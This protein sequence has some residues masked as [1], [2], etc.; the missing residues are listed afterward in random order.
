MR[1]HPAAF[2]LLS[3]FGLAGLLRLARGAARWDEVALAY[4]AYTEPAAQ[5]LA[6][7]EP[8]GALSSWVGLHPPLHAVIM[9]LLE[10]LWP[11]PLAWIG[12]SLLASWLAVVLIGRRA[13]WIAAAA[14]A[15]G[16]LQLA[17]CAE[18]NNYPL[19]VL[20][21]AALLVAPRRPGLGL[22]A[23][24]ALACWAHV[25]TALAA[26]AFV[27]HLAW[28]G[29]LSRS[30]QARLLGGSAL[31]AAPVVV[32]ALRRVGGEGT[33][34]QAR[35]ELS[36]W[37]E[38]AS[39]HL[40]PETVLLVALGG[41][42]LWLGG[43]R[44][45]VLGVALTLGYGAA[46]FAGAAATHQR[47]YLAL[48]GPVL[49]LGLAELPERVGPWRRAARVVLGVLLAVQ[50]GRS[51][52]SALAGAWELQ[53]AGDLERGLDRV[54]VEAA[55][56]DTVWLVAPALQPDDDKEARSPLLWRLNPAEAMPMARPVAFEYLDYRYG[57]PRTW[58]GLTVHTSVELEEQVFDHVARA[59]LAEGHQVWVV[60]YEHAPATGLEA[61]VERTLRPYALLRWSQAY[62]GVPGRLGGDGLG[63]S[64]SLGED[65][66]FQIRGLQ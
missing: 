47:P 33:F 44:P 23:A 36:T 45:R 60:L 49:A 2:G 6:E 30:N 28:T 17:Y 18:V 20:A 25:L 9:G 37:W 3:L 46:L 41:L 52:A 51:G 10:L 65:L 19:A 15:G 13:G 8:L 21:V 24:V 62:P 32:G 39:A 55:P 34:V 38:T 12:L 7:G 5:A 27:L 59:A 61:R 4:A 40:G 50:L 64:A 54:L 56:G 57:Q 43:G 14:L 16:P 22:Y 35:P 63:G 42:G 31:F 11:A 53:D 66:V 48:F 26:G 29:G 1:V 58:R